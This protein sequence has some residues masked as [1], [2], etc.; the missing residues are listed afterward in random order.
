MKRQSLFFIFFI[1]LFLT[2]VQAQDYKR[3]EHPRYSPDGKS[4]VFSATISKGRDDLSKGLAVMSSEGTEVKT[5]TQNVA[6]VFDEYPSLSPDGK[7]IVFLRRTSA[8]V[9]HD[10][11]IIN[12]D[13]SGLK[14]LTKT[15][16]KELRPEFDHGGTGV[17]FARNF[18]TNIF[19]KFGSLHYV[20]LTSLKEKVILAKEFQVT[21]AVP[22]PRGAYFI[23]AA[24][25]GADGKAIDVIN[26]G[27]QV[28]VVSPTGEISPKSTVALPDSKAFIERI[29]TARVA[30]FMLYLSRGGMLA[31]QNYLVTP[32][33]VEKLEIK[34]SDYSLSPDGT[35]LL[36]GEGGSAVYIKGLRAE[37]GA[38]VGKK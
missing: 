18:S 15:P 11:F 23:A 35:K 33:G 24:K 31:Q 25:L 22:A 8:T 10:V 13:G 3:T 28:T 16:E 34:A 32:K 4:I 5:V 38:V 9:L 2:S 36:T 26:N 21:H 20:D 37:R 27:N 14:Q 29:Q 30:E 6:G 1:V 17:V 19:I 12:T 7:K